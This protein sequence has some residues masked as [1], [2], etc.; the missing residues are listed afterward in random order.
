MAP[1]AVGLGLLDWV[2]IAGYTV[3]IGLAGWVSCRRTRTAER[4]MTAGREM[5]GWALALTLFGS[6]VSSISFMANPE[7]SYKE[8]W[9]PFV[10]NLTVPI[11]AAIACW[12]FVP[13]YRR[14][15]HA[16]AYTH[17][18]SRFGSWARLYTV[19]CFNSAPACSQR[20]IC[21]SQVGPT[22]GG[23]AR[24]LPPRRSPRRRGRR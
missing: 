13:F 8:D 24:P 22:G 7:A 19:C 12:V 16:S 10:F 3:L 6:Y 17:L 11:A 9:S 14:L 15:S 4:F 20:H 18:E 2:V 21:F 23:T 5:G 1:L